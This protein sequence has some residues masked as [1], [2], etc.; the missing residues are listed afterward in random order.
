MYDSVWLVLI[1]S[2]SLL[3][4]L[5]L[6]EKVCGGWWWV[7]CWLVLETHNIG[8]IVHEN[9]IIFQRICDVGRI[10]G[11]PVCAQVR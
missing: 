11:G 7:V 6:F 5:E 4:G 9:I 10:T 8:T 2:L 1:P 3:P